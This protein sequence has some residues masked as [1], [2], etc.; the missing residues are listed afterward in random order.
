[1]PSAPISTCARTSPA[2]EPSAAGEPHRDFVVVLRETGYG[3]AGAHGVGAQPLSDSG[4]QLGL[5]CAA[6]DGELRVVIA[7]VSTPRFRPDQLPVAI[8]VDQLLRGNSVGGKLP[9]E[10][11][12]CQHPDGVRQEVDADAQRTDLAG[13]LEHHTA[14]A[15][16]MKSERERQPAHSAT[17]DD[18]ARPLRRV[19]RIGSGRHVHRATAYRRELCGAGVGLG[20]G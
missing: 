9:V 3:H 4:Q 7:R 11:Q 12:P 6:V 10:L 14:D 18:D 2:P 5:Q 1:M 16:R 8:E 13:R 17:C 20:R 15:A 19:G